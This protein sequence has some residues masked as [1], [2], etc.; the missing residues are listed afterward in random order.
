MVYCVCVLCTLM[1][2]IHLPVYVL[3]AG[4]KAKKATETYKSFVEKYAT[5]KSEFEQKMAGTAQVFKPLKH[6]MVASLCGLQHSF[7]SMGDVCVL[8]SVFHICALHHLQI[9]FFPL[10][11][12]ITVETP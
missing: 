7:V 2:I 12:G 1:I 9:V 4:V 10:C 8:E 5:A 3:Q 11:N 6:M